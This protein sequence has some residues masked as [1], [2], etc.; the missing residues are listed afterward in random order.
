MITITEIAENRFELNGIPYFKNFTPVVKGNKIMIVNTYDARTVL[1]QLEDYTEFEVDGSTYASV[2]LL[3]AALLPV[4]FTRSE[5]SSGGTAVWGTITGDITNQTDLV[6]YI[7]ANG[8]GTP[9]DI[10]RFTATDGQT[11][12]ILSD[13]PSNTSVVVSKSPQI[14]G[15]EYTLS[16][17]NPSLKKITFTEGLES[18]DHVEVK[19]TYA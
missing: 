12:F 8:G 11:E 6:N 4:I 2:S 14:F 15:V 7:A 1:V 10:E 19:K 16:Q 5:L 3:Q 17:H 18:G 13:N 9:P